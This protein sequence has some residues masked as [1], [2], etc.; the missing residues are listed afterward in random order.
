MHTRPLTSWIG[1]SLISLVGILSA[2][3]A[4]TTDNAVDGLSAINGTAAPTPTQSE[5]AKK[6]PIDAGD[7]EDSGSAIV[8]KSG[9]FFIF[10]GGSSGTRVYAGTWTQVAKGEPVNIALGDALKVSSRPDWEKNDPRNNNIGISSFVDITGISDYL[11]PLIQFIKSHSSDA[12][13]PVYF[14][15]TG[16]LRALSQ[17]NPDGAQKILDEV[18]RVLTEEAGLSVGSRDDVSM[19]GG[20]M[21]G[22]YAWLA[23]N[24]LSGKFKQ[25]ADAGSMTGIFEIGGAS[26]QV[27]YVPW[28][29]DPPANAP[30]TGLH[31]VRVA[32][33]DYT[34]YATTYENRGANSAFSLYN[35]DDCIPNGGLSSNGQKQTGISNYRKCLAAVQ[36]NAHLDGAICAYDSCG[37]PACDSQQ[38]CEKTAL[39]APPPRGDFVAL[40]VAYSTALTYN[41]SQLNVDT[42]DTAGTAVCG[43]SLEQVTTTFPKSGNFANAGCFNLA[44]LRALIDG[45]G[46][47]KPGEN[48]LGLG[49][50]KV[51]P[52]AK[53]NGIDVS[54]PIGFMTERMERELE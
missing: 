7:R 23:V 19:I 36:A 14:K 22:V 41:I 47:V 12:T 37:I 17:S 11:K 49:K 39:Y 15:A 42:L 20:D 13:T 54:W 30:Q 32:G 18:Y 2:C 8:G 40:S 33:T 27:A 26:L 46:G 28:I 48:G 5:T 25:R 10:D 53:I 1:R 29:G 6:D 45:R 43:L 16:G 35:S 51:Q 44:Y 31:T 4:N 34:V 50:S 24:S 3:N 21:E 38:H 9:R 52:V